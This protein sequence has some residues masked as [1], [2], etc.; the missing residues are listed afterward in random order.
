[1]EVDLDPFQHFR[2]GPKH[3]DNLRIGL[4]D[5]PDQ[6]GQTFGP[7]CKA[8]TGMRRAEKDDTVGAAKDLL[9]V[10]FRTSSRRQESLSPGESAGI[11]SRQVGG[12]I[13]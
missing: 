3:L 13:C 7:L 11:I 10:S 4:F 5:Q 2:I 6:F 8:R 9:K 1:M 12:F